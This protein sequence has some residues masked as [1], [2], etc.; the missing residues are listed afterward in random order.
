MSVFIRAVPLFNVRHHLS[1]ASVA[2]T[3][4]PGTLFSKEGKEGQQD[5][6]FPVA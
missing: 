2:N 5:T 3:D 4:M 1:N 6:K